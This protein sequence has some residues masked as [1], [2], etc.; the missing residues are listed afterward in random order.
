MTRERS[1]LSE[2]TTCPVCGGKMAVRDTDPREQIVIR[3]RR[4]TKCRYEVSTEE[5]V[6]AVVNQGCTQPRV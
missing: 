5:H 4:C 3:V 6:V 2:L 1:V